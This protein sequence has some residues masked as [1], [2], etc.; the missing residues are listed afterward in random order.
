MSFKGVIPLAPSLDHAGFFTKDVRGAALAASILCEQWTTVD[1]SRSPVLGI[2]EG[3]YLDRT[4]PAGLDHFRAACH[5]LSDAGVEIISIEMFPDFDKILHG[6]NS[7]LAAEAAETHRE[8]FR[9]YA[10]TYRKETAGIIRAGWKVDKETTELLREG[11]EKLREVITGVMEGHGLTAFV[12][13]STPGPAPKG[14]E[15]TGDPVMNSVWT[16]AGLPSVNL[17]AGMSDQGLP[18]GLQL[19][20]SK[21]GDEALLDEAE[22][23][24]E[25]VN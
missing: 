5:T 8:W 20:G 3:P 24:A 21:M 23:I 25:L 9:V 13:P 6:I 11:R 19:I 22:R 17:P 16:Y 1:S 10:D 12:T 14:L 18:L 15:S 7:L 4:T 2:P